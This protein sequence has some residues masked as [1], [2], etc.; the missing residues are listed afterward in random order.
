MR[1][2]IIGA[3]NVGALDGIALFDA[4]NPL[5]PGLTLDVGPHGESGAERVQALAA[6]A[7]VVKVFNTTGADNMANPDYDGAPA[8]MFIAGDDAGAK[9]KASSL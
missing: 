5:D 8:T 2:A 4:T 9:E 1:I 7:H 3:G 6:G